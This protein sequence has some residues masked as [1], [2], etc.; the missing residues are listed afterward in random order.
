MFVP[1]D[2]A[3][4]AKEA[5]VF[6][7]SRPDDGLVTLSARPCAG[8]PPALPGL[9]YLAVTLLSADRLR[10]DGSRVPMLPRR[11]LT[12][13]PRDSARNRP[14]VEKGTIAFPLLAIEHQR[15]ASNSPGRRILATSLV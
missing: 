5:F 3:S 13:L 15:K 7:Q 2:W 8:F 9:P 12:S 6:Q 1:G 10:C 4:V 14:R 11:T